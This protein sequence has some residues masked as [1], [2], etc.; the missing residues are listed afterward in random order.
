ML[1][2]QL[3]STLLSIFLRSPKYS[4]NF[5]VFNYTL[6]TS[7]IL[8]ILYTIIYF[9]KICLKTSIMLTVTSLFLF[10]VGYFHEGNEL[11]YAVS[12]MFFMNG[13]AGLATYWAEKNSF[14]GLLGYFS[15]VTIFSVYYLK[16]VIIGLAVPEFI[17]ASFFYLT[18]GVEMV[19]RVFKHG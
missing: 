17:A 13:I 10:L 18:P 5:Y 19:K 7:A 16:L 15:S 9:Q 2:E 12:L 3:F 4:K 11:H 1:K 8:Y 14:Y 6:M